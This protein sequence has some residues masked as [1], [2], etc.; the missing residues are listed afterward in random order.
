ML[1]QETVRRECE[2]RE[3]L[4]AALSKAQ[5]ELL[6]LRSPACH[7]GSSKST[8]SP[9]ETH[10]P[11]GKKHFHLHN[12]ARA[13]LTRPSTFQNTLRPSPACAD[14]DTS[15]G[16]EGAGAAGSVDTLNCGRVLAGDKKQGGTLPRLKPSSTVSEI[17]P[18]GNLAMGRKLT[19][20]WNHK[21]V[22]LVLCWCFIVL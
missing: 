1:L 13:L 21:K 22:T 7:Q 19:S 12:Q 9:M 15:M 4:T 17:K 18:K 20:L 2:E 16:V 11:S 3:E 10:T 14:K 6:G 5:A 8:P